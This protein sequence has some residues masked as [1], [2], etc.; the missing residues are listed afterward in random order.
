MARELY[1]AMETAR[2]EAVGARDMPGTAGNIDAKIAHEA[3]RKGYGRRDQAGRG[4][5]LRRGGLPGPPPGHRARAAPGCG[6]CHGAVA[7]LSSRNRPASTLD[8][9]AGDARRPERP[10]RVSPARSSPISAMATSW[11][12]TRTPRTMPRTTPAKSAEE[13]NDPDSTGEETPDGRRQPTS[14]ARTGRRTSPSHRPVPGA[15]LDGRHGRS[16]TWAT[17]PRCPRARPPL[18]PPAPPPHSDADPTTAS[19]RPTMTRRSAP[20][21]WPNRPS[22]NACAPIS[23]SSW[24]R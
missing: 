13:Q 9:L 20:R 15:G 3:G 24:N 12:T 14:H 10:L 7:R 2:C 19:Y 1:D 6:E 11:A 23:T 18:E 22:W 17:R 5:A 16:G 4:A 8:D 21:T